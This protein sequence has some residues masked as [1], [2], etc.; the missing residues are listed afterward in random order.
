MLLFVYV[1]VAVVF[2]NVTNGYD[3]CLGV[4][5]YVVVTIMICALN[6]DDLCYDICVDVITGVSS[7][8]DYDVIVVIVSNVVVV[9]TKNVVV[10][11]ID[12]T[13]VFIDYDAEYIIIER[14]SYVVD[15]D[16]NVV[17]CVIVL[18][19][20]VVVVVCYDTSIYFDVDY[21]N[22]IIVDVAFYCCHRYYYY[23]CYMWCCI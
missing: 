14:I 15:C 9:F 2:N 12:D 21:V 6:V 23:C 10:D 20:I 17:T 7:V 1:V 3:V 11:V 19:I 4:M 5:R 8:I 22:C 13:V 18:R 16:N